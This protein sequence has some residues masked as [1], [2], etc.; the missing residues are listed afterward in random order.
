[1]CISWH[2]SRQCL[3]G[4][5]EDAPPFLEGLGDQGTWALSA[6]IVRNRTHLIQID[7]EDEWIAKTMKLQH[8]IGTVSGWILRGMPA[9]P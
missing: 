1:M 8:G 7:F 5:C 3:G 6:G 4:S 2:A 9:L